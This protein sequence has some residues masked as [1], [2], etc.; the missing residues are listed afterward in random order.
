MRQR[1]LLER[2]EYWQKI[3]R[4]QDWRI[5]VMMVDSDEIENNAGQCH[6]HQHGKTAVIKLIKPEAYNRTSAFAKAFPDTLDTEVTLVHELLHIPF[7]G[8]FV[9]EEDNELRTDREESALELLAHALVKMD[10]GQV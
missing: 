8:L 3:L 1:E 9:E 5:H 6:V 2:L 10:R 7:D 4:L